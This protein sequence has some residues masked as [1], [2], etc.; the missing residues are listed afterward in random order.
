MSIYDIL[1][2]A[3]L[4]GCI[5]FGFWKGLAWQIASLAAI[6]VSY[7][8]ALNFRGQLAA[9]ISATE[10]WNQF[11]AML[12]IFIAT[13]LVIWVAYGFMKKS[14]EKMRLRG[15]DAQAGA[16]LGAIKGGLLCMLVTL[17]A[18]TLFG[19]NVRQSV[20]QSR[21]GGYIAVGIN[22]LN[23]MIP[24]EVHA[25]LDPHVR[26]FNEDIAEG[27]PGFLPASERRMEQQLRTIQGKFKL[28][29]AT[30]PAEGSQPFGFGEQGGITLDSVPPGGQ[31]PASG[32]QFMEA[33]QEAGRTFLND[34]RNR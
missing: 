4:A 26:R 2:L 19:D 8:I 12:I 10:P 22:R 9:H 14:I 21:S 33:A 1:M 5:L 27:D 25:V 6:F 23:A 17:F 15:F 13:S 16:L 24:Q 3:V 29:S 34:S 11:A 20:I 28:P 32:N 18:V 7:F 30:R 31:V